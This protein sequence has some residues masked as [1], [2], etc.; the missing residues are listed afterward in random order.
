MPVRLASVVDSSVPYSG[1]I[2]GAVESDVNGTDGQVAIP[3]GSQTAI[4]VRDAS[5]SGPISTLRLGL[6]SI[7]VA[8]HQHSL[9]NGIKDAATIVLTENAGQG[10]SHSTVHLQYGTHLDFKLDEPVQ[11]H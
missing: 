7:N 4:M 10:P 9:T 3:A 11:L 2:M 8:G 5:R 6:Y 1:F